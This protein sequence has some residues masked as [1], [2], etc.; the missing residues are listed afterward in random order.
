MVEKAQTKSLPLHV[1]TA[2]AQERESNP[3]GSGAYAW[4][5]SPGHPVGCETALNSCPARV[6]RDCNFEAACGPPKATTYSKKRAPISMFEFGHLDIY[7]SRALRSH[8][9]DKSILLLCLSLFS[10][11]PWIGPPQLK[12]SPHTSPPRGDMGGR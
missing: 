3:G 1:L 2:S 9:R 4:V 6:L 12:Y 5:N 11:Y 8:L 10:R 7:R